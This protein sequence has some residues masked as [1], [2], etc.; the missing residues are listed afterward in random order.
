MPRA[1]EDAG[2]RIALVARRA[3]ERVPPACRPVGQ[4]S[5]GV[6]DGPGFEGGAVVPAAPDVHVRVGKR[7]AQLRRVQPGGCHRI[8]LGFDD[9]EVASGNDACDARGTRGARGE[10]HGQRAV[11]RD[12]SGRDDVHGAVRN[13]DDGARAD[14]VVDGSARPYDDGAVASATVVN[15]RRAYRQRCGQHHAERRAERGNR[16]GCT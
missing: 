1:V 13:G 6:D 8:D 15:R 7:R 4:G 5:P 3:V 12:V 11:G 14:A 9:R 10:A 2:T 16:S